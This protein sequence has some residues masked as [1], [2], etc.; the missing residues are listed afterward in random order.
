MT[1]NSIKPSQIKNSQWVYV[2][3]IPNTITI[4]KIKSDEYI[5]DNFENIVSYKFINDKCIITLKDNNKYGKFMLWYD[6][7]IIDSKWKLATDLFHDNKLENIV[8]MKCSTSMNKPNAYDDNGSV[9]L[10]YCVDSNKK[11]LREIA[12]NI[13]N[14]F[15]YRHKSIISYK[16]NVQ[17]RKGSE[18]KPYRI[19]NHLYKKCESCEKILLYDSDRYHSNCEEC[20]FTEGL[21]NC[22]ICGSTVG[23]M[24]YNEML[25]EE[26]IVPYS[27]KSE[28]ELIWETKNKRCID[29]KKYAHMGLYLRDVYIQ[30]IQESKYREDCP[31]CGIINCNC[32]SGC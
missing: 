13:I 28:K 21:L 2:I 25:V 16:T 20:M 3:E 10:L 29:C 18:Y 1:S 31:F 6:K 7:D 17:T 30:N 4:D 12:K 27:Y 19:K 24:G 23:K 8:N 9:I 32:G 14:L 5:H 22:V 11:E 15:D 26:G